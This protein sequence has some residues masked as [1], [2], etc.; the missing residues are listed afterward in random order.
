M[1]HPDRDPVKVARTPDATH[2][3]VVERYEGASARA[4]PDPKKSPWGASDDTYERLPCRACAHFK[5][6]TIGD[7]G[8]IGNC[9]VTARASRGSQ[10]L[11]PG[12][13]RACGERI[14][15]NRTEEHP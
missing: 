2:A 14:P 4:R 8:G 1:H 5:A 9:V 15:S 11:Y 6:D 7:G 10:P 12:I 3:E 13:S